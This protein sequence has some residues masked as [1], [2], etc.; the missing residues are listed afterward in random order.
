MSNPIDQNEQAHWQSAYLLGGSAAV[1]SL[2]AVIADIMV[3]SMLGGSVSAIPQT[4]VERFAQFQ[5]NAWL[6]LYNLDFLNTLNQILSIPV[7]FALYGAL[8]SVNRPYALLALIVFLVGTSVFTANNT[9]LPMLELSRQ[10]PTASEVQKP[11]LAAAGEAMLARGGHGSMGAFFSFL[12]PTIAA[13]M[14]SLVM[15]GGRVFS[16][17]T[18]FVGI[19]GNILMLV[20]IILVTFA[21]QAKSMAMALAMPG[22]LLLLAWMVMFTLRLFRLWKPEERHTL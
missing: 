17:A 2:L 3:G 5:Q 11:L 12:L 6:G 9:A 20:Y 1:L 14:M 8:R 19:V 7:Y 21:P 13:L 15:L 16:K 22:G 4:A 10:Y 18:A